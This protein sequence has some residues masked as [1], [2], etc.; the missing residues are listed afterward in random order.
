MERESPGRYD[1]GEMPKNKKLGTITKGFE[2]LQPTTIDGIYI[3]MVNVANET[4]AEQWL[5]FPIEFVN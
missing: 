3:H 4:I 5:D 1:S 2:F